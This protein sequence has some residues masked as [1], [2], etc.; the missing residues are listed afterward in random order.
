MAIKDD[1][2]M[3]FDGSGL[4]KEQIAGYL[5]KPTLP[6]TD[7]VY[8]D[9]YSPNKAYQVAVNLPQKP[10]TT[11]DVLPVWFRRVQEGH[12]KLGVAEVLKKHGASPKEI[13]KDTGLFQD[14]HGIWKTEFSDDLKITRNQFDVTTYTTLGSLV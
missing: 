4:T 10:E 1:T 12:P 7:P 6:N 3:D 11:S 9:I 8:M 14:K 13:W 5:P 2:Y